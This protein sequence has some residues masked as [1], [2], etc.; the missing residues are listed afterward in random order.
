[1]LGARGLPAAY[2]TYLTDTIFRA[3]KADPRPARSAPGA[4]WAGWRTPEYHGQLFHG[5]GRAHSRDR[6]RGRCR[7]S[8]PS[9][10]P[11]TGPPGQ[12]HRLGPG[13]EIPAPRADGPPPALAPP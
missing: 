3:T 4:G 6:R 7:G 2:V 12:P 11:G 8:A 5:P 10:L 9:E 13:G 1:M